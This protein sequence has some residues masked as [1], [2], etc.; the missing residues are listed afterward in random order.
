[1]GAKVQLRHVELLE[2][3]FRRRLASTAQKVSVHNLGPLSKRMDR[4]VAWGGHRSLFQYLLMVLLHITLWF[5]ASILISFGNKHLLSELDFRFPF[6]L[7][8]ATNS[9][10]SLATFLI[11]RFRHFAQPPVAR[12]TFVR[13]VIPMA[14]AT[15]LDIGFSNWS[16]VML[17][18]SVHVIIKGAAPLFVMLCGMA[19]HVERPSRRMPLAV[20]L[21]V[22]GLSLV[23]CDRLTL[24]DRPLGIFLGIISVS[25]TGLRWALTQLLMRGVLPAP[26]DVISSRGS[27]S[28]DR[29]QWQEQKRVHPLSTMLNT[30]PIIAAGALVLVFLSEPERRVFSV[31]YGFYMSDRDRLMQLLT[32]LLLLISLV[33]I[34]VL[35]EFH[36]VRLTSSLTLSIFGV[37]KEV[38][39]IL[40]KH[41]FAVAAVV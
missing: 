16:L 10:V 36:L 39:T 22:V 41:A 15:T 11:T 19:L 5:S 35:A 30:M 26:D 34:V 21:I 23:A 13:V 12:R 28:D 1:M 8:F 2:N 18:V 33:F 24:P 20:V 40:S 29:G 6:F 3:P 4:A 31:M 37:I 7:T 32:Y 14:M 38:V 27:R 25:F 9:G 17:S